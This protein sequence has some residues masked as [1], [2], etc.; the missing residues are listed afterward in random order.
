MLVVLPVFTLEHAI[1]KPGIQCNGKMPEE[2]V[3]LAMSAE[4]SMA[5]HFGQHNVVRAAGQSD[6]SCQTLTKAHATRNATT[7]HQ[8]VVS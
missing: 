2:R 1:V 3:Q 4:A 6:R 5:C 7:T 8:L